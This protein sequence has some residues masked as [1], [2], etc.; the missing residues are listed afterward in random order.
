M[1]KNKNKG[2]ERG[3]QA[4]RRPRLVEP[5]W[6]DRMFVRKNISLN[7]PEAKDLANFI[8]P[9]SIACC[10]I[11]ITLQRYAEDIRVLSLLE[12]VDEE[13][14]KTLGN[15]LQAEFEKLN[16]LATE[17]GVKRKAQFPNPVKVDVDI[18]HPYGLEYTKIVENLDNLI[19]L[20]C[21]LFQGR[22]IN[23]V[24]YNQTIRKWWSNIR[25]ANFRL[26]KLSKDTLAQAQ[27]EKARQEEKEAAA[28][29]K[30][31]T[32]L[33][34]VSASIEP[35][36]AEAPEP[37]ETAPGGNNSRKP[38]KA[39]KTGSP[40]PETAENQDKD[41]GAGPLE[42]PGPEEPAAAVL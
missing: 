36:S 17:H 16:L 11:G 24:Q 39:G 21:D 32:A 33:A 40:A 31:E 23:D 3:Q 7:S 27:E 30:D 34:A 8:I 15:E 29:K 25:E 1:A 42:P 35:A 10:R 26:L 20:L 4:S 28:L 18:T 13:I 5:G 22:V 2:K 6:R 37:E 12:S 41:L 9:V 19:L 14:F 38:R